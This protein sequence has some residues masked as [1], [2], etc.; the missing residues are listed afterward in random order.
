[1]G[2]LNMGMIWVVAGAAVNDGDPVYFNPTTGALS[3]VGG[4]ATVGAA[5]PGAGNVGNGTVT[6]ATRRTAQAQW[7]ARGGRCWWSP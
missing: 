5:A 1:M 7:P 2:V 4:A 3:N 6:N